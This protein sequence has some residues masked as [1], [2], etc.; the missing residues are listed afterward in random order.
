MSCYNLMAYVYLGPVTLKGHDG[1]SHHGRWCGTVFVP[2]EFSKSRTGTRVE[3][4]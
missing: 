1:G 3:R 4:G 2:S